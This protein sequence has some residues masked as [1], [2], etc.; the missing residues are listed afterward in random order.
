MYMDFEEMQKNQNKEEPI[1]VNPFERGE[2]RTDYRTGLKS[3]FAVS[4]KNR[5]VDYVTS[6]AIEDKGREYCP[7]EP[8]KYELNKTFFE[9]GN[10][11]RV[12]VIY[13]KYPQ[14]DCSA[15]QAHESN[16]IFERFSYYG[17]SLVIIDSRE[18]EQRFEQFNANNIRDLAD[19]ILEAERRVYT[20]DGID[21]VYLNKNFGRKSSGTLSHSHWQTLGYG[22]ADIPEIVRLRLKK[23]LEFREKRG[24]CLLEYAAGAETQRKLLENSSAIAFAPFAQ[25]YTGESVVMPKRHVSMLSELESDELSGMLSACKEIVAAND[26]YF[27]A[28]AYNILGYSLRKEHAFHACIEIVPRVSEIGPMQMAGYYGSSITPEEYSRSIRSIISQRHE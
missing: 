7:F 26:E 2:I 5:P 16:D 12:R 18:H 28:H 27:G 20:N 15:V 4:R 1:S 21:F 24:Q 10:P 6:E 22:Y 11:C 3:V 8:E 13:N 23:T 17:F 14:L 9:I 25:L 19:A